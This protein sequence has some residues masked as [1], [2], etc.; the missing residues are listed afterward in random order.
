[1]AHLR[2]FRESKTY[3]FDGEKLDNWDFEKWI[4]HMEKFFHYTF[5]ADRDRVLLATTNHLEGDACQ[6]WANIQD[7]PTT[8]LAAITWLRLK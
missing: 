7:D 3:T 2:E 5:V 8:D 4:L 6:W 1:M